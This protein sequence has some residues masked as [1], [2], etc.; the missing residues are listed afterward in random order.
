MLSQ[1]V[2]DES[3]APEVSSRERTVRRQLES[4]GSSVSWTG[5]QNATAKGTQEEVWAH[6]RSKA[7]Q[8][9]RARGGGVDHHRTLSLYK[10]RPLEGG[11]PLAQGMDDERPLAWAMEDWVPLVWA[12][13]SR[14][15]RRT[16]CFLCDL[17]AA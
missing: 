8:L 17:K 15:L 7:P 13:G 3:W 11:A 5:E 4:I 14:G 16:Q 6:R 2:G 10:H 9:E 12:K 1:G